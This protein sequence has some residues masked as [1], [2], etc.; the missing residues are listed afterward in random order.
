MR[1]WL[2]RL[3]LCLIEPPLLWLADQV[4]QWN[5]RRRGYQRFHP[6]SEEDQE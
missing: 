3:I 5:D 4:D 6:P 1:A 2:F